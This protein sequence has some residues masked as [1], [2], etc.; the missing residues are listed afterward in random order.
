M[1]GKINAIV[2]PTLNKVLLVQQ[3][4]AVVYFSHDVIQRS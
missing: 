3:T 4:W 2:N 1:F